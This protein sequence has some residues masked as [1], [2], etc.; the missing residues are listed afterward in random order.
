MPQF[1]FTQAVPQL[2]W[3]AGT[4]FLLLLLSWALLPKVDRVVENRRER[5]ATDLRE[6]EAAR[7]AAEAATA[8]GGSDLADARARALEVTGQARDKASAEMSA[9]LA[10]VDNQ[11]RQEIEA[12][13]AELG[14]TRAKVLAELDGVATEAVVDL[15]GRVSGL[16]VSSEDAAQSVRK[17]AA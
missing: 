13:S 15:V 1:D 9:R 4:F 16:Q 10:E 8:G 6:A 17:L 3:L 12:A 7:D 11:L 14:E 2:L 5:I